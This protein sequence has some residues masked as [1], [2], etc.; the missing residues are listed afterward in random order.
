MALPIIPWSLQQEMLN[1]CEPV[2]KKIEEN[3][4][5]SMPMWTPN[6]SHEFES[7]EII[8]VIYKNLYTAKFIFTLNIC[9]KDV[10]SFLN[11]NCV[12]Y[13]DTKNYID[14]EFNLNQNISNPEKTIL[15]TD[16]IAQFSKNFTLEINITDPKHEIIM[17]RRFD[18]L[19][20]EDYSFTQTWNSNNICY[21][22]VRVSKG[23]ERKS[24]L[25]G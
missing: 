23:N 15:Y 6:L 25:K 9:S 16:I 8:G 21:L 11:E 17:T 24:L 22:T 4:N 13:N 19:L 18:N 5:M 20:L 7:K 2:Y 12:K 1:N 3:N 14:L 10:A